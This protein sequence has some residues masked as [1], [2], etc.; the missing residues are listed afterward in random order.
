MCACFKLYVFY[1]LHRKCC[2]FWYFWVVRSPAATQ[3]ILN[4]VVQALPV[5]CYQIIS[6]HFGENYMTL[7]LTIIKLRCIKLCAVFWNTLNVAPIQKTSS[8]GCQS[9]TLSVHPKYVHCTASHHIHQRSASTY[10]VTVPFDAQFHLSSYYCVHSGAYHH[11]Q[12]QHHRHHRHHS[13]SQTPLH[14]HRLRAPPTDKLTTILQQ[15]CHI[16]MP[17]PNTST[18]QD[19][20]MWQIFVRWWCS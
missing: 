15:I 19:V 1:D 8:G 3:R 9:H 11:H 6:G 17:E 14:G 20:G 4:C 13:Y 16:A 7:W 5:L 12:Q 10:N 2:R 18:C